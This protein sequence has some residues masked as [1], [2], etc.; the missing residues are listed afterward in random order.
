MRKARLGQRGV[1]L[2]RCCIAFFLLFL[3]SAAAMPKIMA[4]W[5]NAML[6]YEVQHLAADIRWIQELTRTAVYY[7]DG[8]PLEDT[9]ASP[10][11]IRISDTYYEIRYTP[12]EK[13]ERHYFRSGITA[14]SSTLYRLC[15][16]HD[17]YFSNR[18]MGTIYLT[19]KGVN[20]MRRKIVIDAIGRVRVD[21]SS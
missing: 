11:E 18:T 21:R 13:G 20:Q 16:T 19:W 17:G 9:V 3:L 2:F 4:F 7:N 8:M 1:L 6:D 10:P 14:Y 15:F 5:K 12:E